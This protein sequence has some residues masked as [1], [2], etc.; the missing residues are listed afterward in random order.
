M[1][2][3]TIGIP[4]LGSDL[5]C[6]YMQYKYVQCL[7]KAGAVVQILPQKIDADYIAGIVTQCDGLVFPGGP[8][9]QP[10]LYGKEVESGCGKPDRMRDAFELPLLKS[11]LEAGKP[12]FCIC[13]GMQLLNVALGGTLY[14]DIKPRQKCRHSDFWHRATATHSVEL[15]TDSL[16]SGILGSDTA[17]V[18]SIHHQA[19]DDLGKGLWVAAASPDGFPE[20]LEIEEYPFCLAVQWHPEHM[21]IRTPAQQKLFL[22][23]TEACRKNSTRVSGAALQ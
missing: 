20:A 22:A 21:A 6:E 4:R 18:N 15:D 12:L 9:I 13:R 19:V 5:Y 14:Q 2:Y 7:R 16:V 17:S 23:F 11:A 10:A 8:D 1:I 3:P